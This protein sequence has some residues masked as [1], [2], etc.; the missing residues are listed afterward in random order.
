[1][2]GKR[3]YT[4]KT[5]AEKAKTLQ[6]LDSGMSMR[7]CATKY[8]VFVGMIINWKNNKS[9]IISSIFEFTSLSHK[10]F[11][12]VN[13]NDKVIDERV[14]EWFANARCQ[15]I[16]VPSPIL[17]TKV[18]QV[19]A[20]IGLN[21]F[22]ASNGWLEAFRKRHYIQF[23]LL[24]RESTGMDENVVNHWKQNLP[25]IIQ[26]Y[27]TRDI[28]NMD[29]TRLFWKGVPNRNLVLQGERCRANKLAKERITIA[30]FCSAIGENF[31]PLMIGKL[32]MPQAFNK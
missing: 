30:L 16:H 1:M 4:E 8:F 6:D 32:Q 5:L 20:S 9:E 19:V 17:Q 21:N 31:K 23:R 28:W 2:S 11:A 15:N 24:F 29:K 26:G 27:E 13:D 18:L 25:N 14:Y 10:R 3:K 22:K 12:Q 7:A